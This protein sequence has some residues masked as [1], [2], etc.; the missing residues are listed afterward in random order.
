[1]RFH[2]IYLKIRF[3]GDILLKNTILVEMF[4]CIVRQFHRA[5]SSTSRQCSGFLSNCHPRD[6]H[7][8][9]S[10]GG[11]QIST[12]HPFSPVHSEV[13]GAWAEN[14]HDT[15]SYS[16]T[17]ILRGPNAIVNVVFT[18][19]PR[20]I[21]SGTIRPFALFFHTEGRKHFS[22]CRKIEDCLLVLPAGANYY[23]CVEER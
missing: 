12:F 14:R 19:M 13:C 22:G 11:E 17:L 5:A 16:A 4:V 1:M 20:N 8:S 9:S 7:R 3:G 10:A 2:P 21:R 6:H 23:P 15:P 18:E